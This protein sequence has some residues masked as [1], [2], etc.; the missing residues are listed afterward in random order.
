MA[1]TLCFGA[2]NAR[3]RPLSNNKLN[4]A[5]MAEWSNAHDSKS[6]YVGIRTGVRIP[7]SAPKTARHFLWLAVFGVRVARTPAVRARQ[8]SCRRFA[9]IRKIPLFNLRPYWRAKHGNGDCR[10]FLREVGEEWEKKFKRLVRGNGV[11]M[12]CLKFHCELVP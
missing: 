12:L 1:S 4:N 6:C 8:R 11:P 7:L 3:I 5:E 9:R 10:S 2:T